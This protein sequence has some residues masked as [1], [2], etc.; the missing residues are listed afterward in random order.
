MTTLSRTARAKRRF[1]PDQL[2]AVRLLAGLTVLVTCVLL[3][4]A[5][6]NYVREGDGVGGDFLANYTGGVLARRDSD[7]LYDLQAQ[8][9]TQI[10]VSPSGAQDDDL[11]PFV[12]PPF[13]ALA[14][15]PLSALSY[16]VALAIFA[17]VNLVL[18]A[19][20]GALLHRELAPVAGRLRTTVLACTL[21]SIPVVVTL[22]WG[23]VDLIVA[24]ALLLGWQLLRTNRDVAA[25]AVLSLALVKPHFL[26][27]VVLLLLWQ[28]RWRTLA[29]LGAIGLAAFA[30]PLAV[31]G[32]GVTIDY[33]GLITG[34]RDM[35]ATMDVR[36]EVMANWRGLIASIAGRD[37]LVYWAPGALA[38]GAGALY[39]SARRW[40]EGASSPRAYALASILPLLVSP[41]VHMES[42]LL[43]FVAIALMIGGAGAR[44]LA[45]PGRRRLDAEL[46]LL[47]LVPVL[48]MGWFLTANGLAVMVFVT[49]G[50]F[51]WCALTRLPA[52]ETAGASEPVALAA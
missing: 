47:Y 16:Q 7:H 51:A 48:F 46:V 1:T 36:P 31:M 52:V 49:V 27:G 14:F 20:F 17:A 43:L 13:A 37:S 41:H 21:C 6:T 34:V 4:V 2:T 23:Q 9:A 3:T 42:M 32:P 19:C 26:L 35:P 40:R 33:A 18:L 28:H 25:G 38:V 22:S 10:D 29:T 24:I 39:V 45:L 8:A 30:A 5:V 15:A 44:E 11:L 50:V 12:L